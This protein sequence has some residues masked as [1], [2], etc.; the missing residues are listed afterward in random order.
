MVM[1]TMGSDLSMSG[2]CDKCTKKDPA[3]H[4]CFAVCAGLQAAVPVVCIIRVPARSLLTPF[5]E[6]QVDGSTVSPDLPPP[7]LSVL[8]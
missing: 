2:M 3:T 7:K 4:A 5:A 1:D 6:R 8:A